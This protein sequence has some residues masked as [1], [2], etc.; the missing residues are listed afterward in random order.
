VNAAIVRHRSNALKALE[1]NDREIAHISLNAINA[2][3][4][5]DY[6]V[7]VNTQKYE[8]AIEDTWSIY[9]GYC[10]EEFPLS[11]I[12]PFDLLLNSI[13]SIILGLDVM[14]VWLCPKCNEENPYYQ[15]KKKL[16]KFQNPIYTK[17][18]PEVPPYKGLI[19]RV[20]YEQ[21]LRKWFHTY[22]GELEQQISLYRTDWQSQQGDDPNIGE[23]E[24]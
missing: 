21:S 11:E 3:L 19:N 24:E 10:E 2:L 1:N 23:I 17:I 7:E 15:A 9:C 12:R 6:K 14:R 22:L 8:K 20:G 5:E 18:V 16:V 13:E 4:P